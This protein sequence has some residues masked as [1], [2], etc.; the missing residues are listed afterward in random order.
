LAFLSSK[1]GGLY[2]S[3]L[4]ISETVLIVNSLGARE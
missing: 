2:R 3:Q 4:T 1:G